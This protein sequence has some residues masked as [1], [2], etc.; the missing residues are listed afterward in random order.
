MAP[1]LLA[2][3]AELSDDNMEHLMAVET[4]FSNDTLLDL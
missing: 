4:L 2:L 1:P 3:Q